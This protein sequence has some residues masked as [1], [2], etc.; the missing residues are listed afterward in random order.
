MSEAGRSDDEALA[1]GLKRIASADAADI[2]RTFG[3][4]RCVMRGLR[5]LTP[6]CG[7]IAGR[8]RTIQFLPAREDLQKP[9]NG[10]VNRLLYDAMR[11]GD[12]LV[13]DA[14]GRDDVAALGDMMFARLIARGAAGVVVD[15]AVRDLVSVSGVPF[16]VYAKTTAPASFMGH[17]QPW[18][19]DVPI[20][21][22][23]VFVNPR[24]WIIADG[25][26]VVVVPD[27]LA[28]ELVILL[29]S[30]KRK[31]A[32]SRA[33]LKGGHGLDDAYPLPD[34]MRQFQSQFERDGTLPPA[35]R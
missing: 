20:Q 16:G 1:E 4:S 27:R 24:D 15:G 28:A 33:L 7:G 17:L 14:M 3:V 11:P 18:A 29:A 13:L 12:I 10:P 34:H 6:S 26:G 5:S 21:C 35:K 25:D 9:A 8:A 2:L 30:R 32:F 19:A 31:D 23:G 22:G